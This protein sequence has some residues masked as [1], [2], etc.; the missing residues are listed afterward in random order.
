MG[1]VN[2]IAKLQIRFLKMPTGVGIL[3]NINF[4]SV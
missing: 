3:F 1:L 4:N 2:Q